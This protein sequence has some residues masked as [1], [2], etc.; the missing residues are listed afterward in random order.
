MNVE[1]DS[2]QISHDWVDPVRMAALCALLGLSE[3]R[4]VP[5]A[6]HVM[7]W[8]ARPNAELGRDGHPKLGGLIPDLGL[9]RRMWAGGRLRFHAPLELGASAQ[10][11]SRLLGSKRKTGRSGDLAFI[12]LEH[13]I[14][15]NGD[16]VIEDIQDLVYR[17]DP[18]LDAP[19]PKAPAAP[20]DADISQTLSFS[21]T[22]LFRYSALTFN[23]HRIHYDRDYAREVEGYP[24]LVV[25]G[26]LLAQHLILLAERHLGQLD[27]FS[28]R[29]TA[30]LF[31]D[32]A[33]T[34]ALRESSDGLALWVAAP[35]GRQCM[36]ATAS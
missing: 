11:S 2:L 5:F 10:K 28:F 22:D 21:T 20:T 1:T 27:H 29:A 6:H 19:R 13:R 26:P 30:P 8:D 34:L 24:G 16:L 15:Q 14:S 36:Q 17:Q 25:H 12:S 7:F 18:D 35:D 32:E 9:P 23:G 3:I 4:A 33:A 31:D